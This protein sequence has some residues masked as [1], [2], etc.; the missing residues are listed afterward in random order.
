MMHR[1]RITGD[2]VG[3]TGVVRPHC[4]YQ[5]APVVSVDSPWVLALVRMP[6][7]LECGW[8]RAAVSEVEVWFVL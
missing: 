2:V 5:H 3:R 1:C 4:T 6:V 7:R 8:E